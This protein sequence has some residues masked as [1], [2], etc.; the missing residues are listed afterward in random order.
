MNTVGSKV[1]LDCD[2]CFYNADDDSQVLPVTTTCLG[3]NGTW[4]EKP[5][6]CTDGDIILYLLCCV[7]NI[8]KLFLFLIITSIPILVYFDLAAR[9]I[10]CHLF[11][12]AIFNKCLMLI[13][14]WNFKYP[15]RQNGDHRSVTVA[16]GV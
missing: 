4:S 7:F 16:W 10:T 11:W 14:K 12:Y 3:D 8:S 9:P 15:L 2:V 13:A 1:V 6:N 5:F